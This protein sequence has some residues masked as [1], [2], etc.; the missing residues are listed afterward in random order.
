MLF[1]DEC[2]EVYPGA[3]L[4]AWNVGGSH[5]SR[6]N[7]WGRDGGVVLFCSFQVVVTVRCQRVDQDAL[8]SW[9]NR[10]RRIFLYCI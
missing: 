9:V 10:R 8:L 2:D 4:V 5:R 3:I 7:L 6:G 1:S